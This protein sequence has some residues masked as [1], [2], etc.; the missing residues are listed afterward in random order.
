MEEELRLGICKGMPQVQHRWSQLPRELFL[1]AV[2]NVSPEQSRPR[3]SHLIPL[4]CQCC[5]WCHPVLSSILDEDANQALDLAAQPVPANCCASC[6]DCHDV[7]WLA[8]QVTCELRRNHLLACYSRHSA[9][10][11]IAWPASH[12]GDL[13]RGSDALS[14]VCNQ[15]ACRGH[16]HTCIAATVTRAGPHCKRAALLTLAD[17]QACAC[18]QRSQPTAHGCMLTLVTLLTLTHKLFLRAIHC[19]VVQYSAVSGIGLACATQLSVHAVK[20]PWFCCLSYYVCSGTS[21]H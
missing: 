5:R 12:A 9:D 15:L 6:E 19:A 17:M 18:P 13:P 20:G 11:Y 7:N 10:T 4:V 1:Q 21:L 2:A 3:P 14:V 16:A 8:D